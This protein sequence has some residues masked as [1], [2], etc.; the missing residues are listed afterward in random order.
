[1]KLLRFCVISLWPICGVLADEDVI[2]SQ[3]PDGKF[4]LQLASAV[5]GSAASIIDI[6]SHAVVVG[7]DDLKVS[8]ELPSSGGETKLVWSADSKRV[9]YCYT[10]HNRNNSGTNVQVFIWN[11]SKFEE[12]DL[13]ELPKPKM[14][15]S[16]DAAATQH[17]EKLVP[18]HWLKSGTL[19]LSYDVDIGSEQ[20]WTRIVT[21]GFDAKG[22][23][24]VQKVEQKSS[25]SAK[26]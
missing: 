23:A 7:E 19:V 4:A 6:R 15:T 14:K 17:F 24:T 2:K 26:P 18:L 22:N 8:T 25:A 9:A 10:E 13:P 3:S 5:G 20:P 1:M 16:T 21:I 12:V 11:G